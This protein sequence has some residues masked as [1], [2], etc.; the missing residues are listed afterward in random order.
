[1]DGFALRLI[2]MATMLIDHIGW[3]F[4]KTPM[5][6]T[7]I[8]RI[9]F[10]IYAFLLA[11]GFL[12]IHADRN[13]L[14]KHFSILIVLAVVSEPCY[15]LMESGLKF[16]DYLNSQSNMITLLIGYLCMLATEALIPSDSV[17]TDHVSWE[18]IAALISAYALAGFANYMLKDNY[19]CVGPW[20]VTAFYWYI[21]VSKSDAKAGH[22]WSW[23]RRL[24]V[25]LL[26]FLCYLPLYFWVRSGFG[27][28]ARWWQEVVNYA[29][30]IAGHAIVALI[31]SLYNGEL[32][33]HEKWFNRLFLSFYPLHMFIIGLIRILSGA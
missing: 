16:A 5:Y 22:S 26:I 3:N 14:I 31:I 9:A 12:I 8:G 23:K 25:L 32:G 4:L 24:L 17:N 6:L 28:A 10:P 15:D 21:R 2:A 13:R 1:M 20:L 30:W 33:Y 27:D 7:W 18:R 11:E 29:P 19:N